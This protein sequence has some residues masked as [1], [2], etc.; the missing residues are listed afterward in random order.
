MFSKITITALFSAAIAAALPG[1]S[2]WSGSGNHTGGWGGGYVK[3][4][5][6]TSYSTAY[7]TTSTVLPVVQSRTT[8]V[9]SYITKDTVATYTSLVTNERVITSYEEECIT[10]SYPVTTVVYVSKVV[11]NEVPVYETETC[12]E[13]S[14]YTKASQY[15]ISTA[16]PSVEV[17]TEY[18]TKFATSSAVS[19]ATTCTPYVITKAGW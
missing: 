4:Q 3:S 6:A 2:P 13:T 10:T 7:Y 17:C 16:V 15:A 14:I 9:P 19:A 18:E 11:T 5:C 1:S 8:W 12:T